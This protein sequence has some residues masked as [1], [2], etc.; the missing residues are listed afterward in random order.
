[1][2]IISYKR[3][4]HSLAPIRNTIPCIIKK[5][6]NNWYT[7]PMADPRGDDGAGIEIKR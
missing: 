1:M 3:E 6:S 4:N 2:P 7:Y 5:K